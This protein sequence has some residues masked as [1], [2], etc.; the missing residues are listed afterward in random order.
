[1]DGVGAISA[2]E[3][4]ELALLGEHLTH[5]EI[6]GRLVISR[7]PPWYGQLLCQWRAALVAE[8]AVL[9]DHPDAP[10]RCADAERTCSGNPVAAAMALRASAVAAGDS[11]NLVALAAQLSNGGAPYQAARTLILAGGTY[12]PIGEARLGQLVT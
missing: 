8:A 5:A 3:T 4:E 12:R 7:D 10:Q 9:A 2:R 11:S 1:V 6:A